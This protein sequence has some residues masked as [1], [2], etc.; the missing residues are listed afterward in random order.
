MRLS[1]LSYSAI[2]TSEANRWGFVYFHVLHELLPGKHS[3]HVF[4][5]D[6]NFQRQSRIQINLHGNISLSVS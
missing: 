3:A 4:C 1:A 2:F 5:G 6:T